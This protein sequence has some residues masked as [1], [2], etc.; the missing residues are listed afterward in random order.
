MIF[1][2]PFNF[3]PVY[4]KNIFD[5]STYLFVFLK[6]KTDNNQ[7][8]NTFIRYI[9]VCN[10]NDSFFR[11]HDEFYN[12]LKIQNIINWNILN[13]IVRQYGVIIKS[14]NRFKKEC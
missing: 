3:F 8:L 9:T 13:G 4:L 14:K 5:I 11:I 10:D 7:I 1:R 12:F 2:I 6:A